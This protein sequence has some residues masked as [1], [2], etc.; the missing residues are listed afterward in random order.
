MSRLLERPVQSS[1]SFMTGCAKK[2]EG[3][4]VVGSTLDV[5]SPAV[6]TINK[7]EAYYGDATIAGKPLPC[8]IRAN[9]A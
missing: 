6:A 5:T 2:E 7:G 8:W 3:M 9:Q 1:S 4:N